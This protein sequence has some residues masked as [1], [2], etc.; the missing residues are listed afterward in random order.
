MSLRVLAVVPAR[1]GSQRVPSKNLER[2]GGRTLVRRALDTALDAGC[3]AT[4]ALS[5]DAPAILAEADGL[6]SVRRIRR[7]AELAGDT[8]L[9]YD[10]VVH[11]LETVE[12]A[13]GG[14]A[15]F[16]AVAVI[17]ATSPFTAPEDLTGATT[18][19]ERSGA[20]AVV[21]VARVEAGQHP[22]KLKRMEGDRLLPYLADDGM[23]PSHRLPELWRRNGSIYLYRRVVIDGGSFDAADLRGYAMPPER[24]HDIDTPTDL[25]FARFLAER[26]PSALAST[27]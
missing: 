19:L 15:P 26:G 8:A 4:V 6:G 10:V 2:I 23:A 27:P 22:L 24:S 12:Q 16:D 11:A 14:G 1:A 18:L 5:S 25:A 21:S 7:P 13:Q 17:Q 20:D 9:V 3:F